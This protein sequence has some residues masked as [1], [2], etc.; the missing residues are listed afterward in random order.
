MKQK[1]ILTALALIACGFSPANA[2]TV[3]QSALEGADASQTLIA[4][5]SAI[6]GDEIEVKLETSARPT[7]WVHIFIDTDGD[8]STGF[9]H[10]LGGRAGRGLDVM[11]EGDLV[12]QF[13]G[14][15]P[16]EW[17][18][19]PQSG[20]AISRSIRGN[21]MAVDVPMQAIDDLGDAAS[22]FA[23]SYDAAYMTAVDSLPRAGS[24]WRIRE[25]GTAS[26]SRD[27]A[28]SSPE[29]G[30]RA[31]VAE[32]KTL[33]SARGPIDRRAAFDGIESYAC[34][35]GENKIAD[36]SARDAVI[37]EPRNQTV[38][39]IAALQAA[40]T[41]VIG[42]ISIGEDD[43]LRV[44]D[45]QG[46]G[47]YDSGYFDRN[48]DN[49]PDKNPTWNSYYADAREPAWRRYFLDNAYKMRQEKGVDGFFLDTIDTSDLYKESAAAMVSLIRELRAQ[50]PDSVIVLNRGFHTVEE[51]APDVDGVMFE[52]FTTSYDWSSS[53]YITMRP[54][55]WDW[56]LYV[57]EE[58]LKPAME[59]HGLVV[60]SLDY[61]RSGDAPE[62]KTAF[63]RAASFGYVPE[64]STIM[65]DA[66]YEVDYVGEP[67]PKYLQVQSTPEVMSHVLD[68]SQNGFPEK[69]RIVP[70]SVYSDYAVSP[71]VDGVAAKETLDW[72]HRAWASREIADSHSL[73]FRMPEPTDAEWLQIDWASDNGIDYPSRSFRVEAKTADEKDW[74]AL[75]IIEANEAPSNKVALD[76]G[77][78]TAL[79]IVQDAGDG[80]P[81]RPDLMWVEQVRLLR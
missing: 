27:A 34:Y 43:A 35:Y 79:R 33:A 3:E 64:V 50:N 53:E 10:Y 13:S 17:S 24:T 65:L 55:A 6:S 31:S 11:I 25:K 22:L 15:T 74:H 21:T 38:E 77:E 18:W 69:T 54:S 45:G 76:A 59:D 62:V 66:I 20:L 71:V 52:S 63:D 14:A 47:G 42:Y 26:D 9:N 78:V 23:V 46:A 12:Y 1:L 75:A 80:S 73:E 5:T 58:T 40:D 56:G 28:A 37:I 19:A 29:S 61:T 8:A 70:S 48:N 81:K 41:L 4:G 49:L 51:L 44:G 39:N 57:H 36:M 32:K 60:L 2:G 7:E 68:R 16:S 72:R 30:A 67:D